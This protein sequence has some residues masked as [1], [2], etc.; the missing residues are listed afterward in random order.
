MADVMIPVPDDTE[1]LFLDLPTGV[2]MRVLRRGSGTPVL[3]VPGWTCSADFFSPQLAGLASDCEVIAIDPR[4][5]GGSS[6][7]TEGNSFRQRGADL[8]AVIAELGLDRPII[9]GWSFG[10]YDVLAYLRD[11]GTDGVRG[12]V[13]C[14]E[15]PKCPAD[16][17]NSDDWGE[18]PLTP[19]GLPALLRM[20][21]DDRLGFWTWYAKYMIGLPED[22]ADDH[23]D[24]ARIVELGM[25]APDY[26]AIMTAADGVSSDFTETT[27]SVDAAVP[28]LFIAREDWADDARRWVSSHMPTA[29]FATMPTHMGFVTDPDGFN[30]IVRDFANQA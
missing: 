11:H 29:Q 6:K 27:E 5:H 12:V 3:L 4:G 20:M 9:L 10:A 24:V 16:P 14:D 19:D 30:A 15:T 25:Q 7:P 28:T 13:I 2:T 18:A 21:I 8:A 17:T 22:T 26:V 23:P 1:E